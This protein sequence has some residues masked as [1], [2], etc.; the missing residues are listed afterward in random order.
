[1]DIWGIR[2]IKFIGDYRY[3]G[4]SSVR[5]INDASGHY[6]YSRVASGC[7]LVV[8]GR[9]LFENITKLCRLRM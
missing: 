8:W 4:V 2:G 6:Q 5:S 1:M 9:V 7:A 3:N